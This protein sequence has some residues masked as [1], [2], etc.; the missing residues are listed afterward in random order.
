MVNKSP[1]TETDLLQKIETITQELQVL[2]SE[3]RMCGDRGHLQV[4]C[5]K[6][7]ECELRLP[8]NEKPYQTRTVFTQPLTD[9]AGDATL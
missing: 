2:K 4:N 7:K 1:D 5:P 6:V 9:Y 8:E 3:C